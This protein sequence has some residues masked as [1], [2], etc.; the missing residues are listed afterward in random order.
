MEISIPTLILVIGIVH[1]I[2]LSI[3]VHQYYVN[4]IYKG[5]GWWVLWCLA[6]IIGFTAMFF[7]NIPNIFPLVVIV[8]NFMIVGGAAFL[9]IGVRKFFNKSANLKLILPIFSIF[10]LSLV[11][12]LIIE[13]NIRIR[14]FIIA[15]TIALFAFISAYTCI[16]SRNKNLRTMANFNA[17][18]FII[19]GSVFV[20]RLYL[21]FTKNYTEDIFAQSIYNYLPFLDA[22]IIGILWTFGLIV[23]INQ[24]LNSELNESKDELRLIFNTSPDA[25]II[26]TVYDGT[27][28]DINDSFTLIS[29]FTRQE[30]IGKPTTEINLWKT[31]E[32]RIKV[33]EL[34][35]KQGYC[36]NFEATFQLKNGSEI[37]GLLSAKIINLHGV[38]HILSITRNITEIKLLENDVIKL[39]EES[40]HS[41]NALLSI[42]ED[43]MLIQER[44]KESE[45]KFRNLFESMNVGIGIVDKFENFIFTNPETEKIFGVKQ[46]NLVGKNL[47]EFIPIEDMELIYKETE[48]RKQKISSAYEVNIVQPNGN[49]RLILISAAPQFNL[50]GEFT[51]S[52]AIIQDITEQKQIQN[53][54]KKSEEQY[55][56]LFNNTGAIFCIIDVDKTISLINPEFEKTLGY[57]KDE[58]ENKRPFTDFIHPEDL[59]KMIEYHV[60]R[61]I[62]KNSVPNKYEFRIVDKKGNFKAMYLNVDMLPGTDKSIATLT[63]V[64]DL[65]N[66]HSK[67]IENENR[68]RL[69]SEKITDVIWL[70]DLS[71]KSSYVSPSIERFTGFTPEEYLQQTIETRFKKDSAIHAIQ[72]FGNELKKYQ[73]NPE[74]L[75]GYSIKM[76]LEYLCKDENT[77]WGELIITPYYN[78][79]NKL[80]G[81]HGV[82][83][84]I[85]ERKETEQTLKDIIEKNPISIQIVDKDGYTQHV[86]PAFIKLFGVLPPKD[87]SIFSNLQHLNQDVY[88]LKVK[89]GEIVRLPDLYYNP[90]DF[91]KETPDN[92]QWISAIIFP[93]KDKNG[94]PDRFVFMHENITERKNANETIFQSKKDWE[95]TFDSITDMITIHDKNYNI[96]RANKAGDI[97]LNLPTFKNLAESKCYSFYHGAS[98][99]PDGCPSCDCLKSGLPGVF[100]LFEPHLSRFLEIRAI[101]RFYSTNQAVGMIHISRDITERKKAEQELIKAKEK[102]EESEIRVS[103]YFKYAPDGL[104][105]ADENGNYVEVNPAASKITGYSAEELCSMNLLDLIPDREKPYAIQ[106]FKNVKISGHFSGESHFQRKDKTF[107]YWIVNAVKL[108]ESNY[109][110]FVKEITERK[111]HETL[112][113]IAKHK[114]EKQKLVIALHNERL[115]SLLKISQYQTQSIQE[116]LDFALEE[117]IKLTESKIGYIFFYDNEKRQFILNSWSNEAMKECAVTN[118]QTVYD[119]DKTGI[120]GE[121]VRQQKPIIINDYELANPYKKGIPEGHVRLSK[122]LTIP[123][124]SDNKIVAVAGVANKKCNY[125]DSDIKQLTLLMDSVW[126]MAERISLIENLKAAKEKAEESGKL[127]SAFLAN[128]S[129]EIRTPMN[130]IIG[131]SD[132]LKKRIEPNSQTDKFIELINS[133]SNQLLSIVD[134]IVNISKLEIKQSI[135][136]ISEIQLDKFLDDIYVSFELVKI[137]KTTVNLILKKPQSHENLSIKCDKV[138]LNQI[139]SNLL[140]NAMKFTQEGSITFGYT[141]EMLDTM[142]LKFFVSDTGIGIPKD[143]QQLIFDRFRQADETIARKYGGNGLGLSISKGF[144]ELMGGKIWVESEDN[145]KGSTFYF[146]IPIV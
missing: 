132:L 144:V 66:A 50:S 15:A 107:G 21:F 19:H 38:P 45:E 93:L 11:Y 92:P 141:V 34:L 63:D 58:V 131:F 23:M 3:F 139:L 135:L 146:T 4:K 72:V 40:E 56:F 143:K 130:S 75:E 109:L 20:F 82:T 102:A 48:I 43:Q 124:F 51:G 18:V 98:A 73:E 85:T 136:N 42:L 22:F 14:S 35:E 55:R 16:V 77:K 128:I 8:Q 71:G 120:W 95:D 97:M 1:L 118:P 145:K 60:Q 31:N 81:I 87:F 25:A 140:K 10:A 137:K 41:K 134:D 113:L 90:H 114:A 84:D 67:I 94:V 9:Y 36:E 46:G 104:F 44:L 62:N 69:I 126:R 96:V 30:A 121:A 33:V 127:K 106:H 57:T 61:R 116:L 27:I 68:Y 117:A 99:P 24:R 91:V 70:M 6:E 78:E 7:R 112:L 100:E 88:I 115:E 26:T 129:H 119:L 28:V 80:I 39:L 122:F 17:V 76:E 47:S 133:N 29:G 52:Q 101:P 32:D 86:N 53:E 74:K 2:Q 37:I 54:L 5:I 103:N 65:K 125:N 89:N 105:I 108:N 111:K 138:K 49:N 13:D 12:F 83:R 123:V 79:Q 142:A 110:G 64:T 59:P